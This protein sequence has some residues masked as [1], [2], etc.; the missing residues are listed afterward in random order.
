MQNLEN[1]SKIKELRDTSIII[2]KLIT[3]TLPD[4]ILFINNYFNF[5]KLI[6]ILK[7]KR[8]AVY[9]IMKSG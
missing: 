5:I 2:I 4:I 8:I 6:V 1:K 3:D 7:T 9:D